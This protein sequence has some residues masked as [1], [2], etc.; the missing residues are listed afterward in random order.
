MGT[1]CLQ[2]TGPGILSPDEISEICKLDA[3]LLGE[4]YARQDQA[5]A[6][7]AKTEK[8]DDDDDDDDE[9]EESQLCNALCTLPSTLMEH[10]PEVFAERCLPLFLPI[11]Q[12]FVQP[13][14]EVT[15]RMQAMLL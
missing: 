2:K 5:K 7:T 10:Y 13:D 1:G 4:S 6:G 11:V 8:D 9:Q 15:K 3:K 14:V 12:Q